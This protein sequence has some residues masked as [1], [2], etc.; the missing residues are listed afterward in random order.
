MQFTFGCTHT[1]LWKSFFR[2]WGVFS[3]KA[4]NFI[5]S[6]AQCVSFFQVYWIV[7]KKYWL[8]SDIYT[9][10]N[11][12]HTQK[13]LPLFFQESW[14]QEIANTHTHT[15]THSLSLSLSLTH[16]HQTLTHSALLY[17]EGFGV[18]AALTCPKTQPQFLLLPRPC[19][20]HSILLSWICTF[21]P[22]CEIDL[23]LF[24]C[25]FLNIVWNWFLSSFCSPYSIYPYVPTQN[26]I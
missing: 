25:I 1:L 6:V 19:L 17:F 4:V 24:T 26:V 9:Q 3:K 13:N 16:S 8:L 15:H 12:T 23:F 20:V 5:G 2:K 11:H 22:F 7:C 21:S 14:C 10:K 18:S